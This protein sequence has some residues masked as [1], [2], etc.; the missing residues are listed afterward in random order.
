MAQL[1]HAQGYSPQSNRKLEEGERSSELGRP[2]PAYQPRGEAGAGSGV[3][4]HFAGHQEKGTDGQLRQWGS[5]MAG[6]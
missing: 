5:T 6:G 4:G 2:V 3:A 1:L